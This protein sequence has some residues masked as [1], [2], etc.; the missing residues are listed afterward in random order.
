MSNK[1]STLA[2]ALALVATAALPAGADILRR[3]GSLC[4][5]KYTSRDLV[6]VDER[7]IYN[8]STTATA[9]VTCPVVDAVTTQFVYRAEGNY[10]G[11]YTQDGRA[12]VQAITVLGRDLSSTAPVSCYVFATEEQGSSSWGPTRYMCTSWGGCADAPAADYTGNG[13]VQWDMQMF[14]GMTNY[15]SLYHLG[16]VCNLPPASASG[17]SYVKSIVA[18]NT[19]RAIWT[20][21]DDTYFFSIEM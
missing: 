2:A 14:P 21:R 10:S 5:P 4:A 16:V 7:G 11:G 19:V 8:G 1:I 13:S 17:T 12:M 6:G 15:Y 3:H 18:A 20:W 9:S